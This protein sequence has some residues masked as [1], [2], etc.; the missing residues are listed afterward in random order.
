[1]RFSQTS[2]LLKARMIVLLAFNS[3]TLGFF[4]LKGYL[5]FLLFFASTCRSKNEFASC[6]EYQA[7]ITNDSLTFVTIDYEVPLA[8]GDSL[9]YQNFDILLDGVNTFLFLIND[10][11]HY[12]EIYN[13]TDRIKIYSKPISD[14]ILIGEPNLI[15]NS[16]HFLGF[17]SIYLASEQ[18][19]F[20]IDT[21][22]VKQK[23]IINQ[24]ISK[25]LNPLKLYN[26]NHCPL[27]YDRHLKGLLLQSY[28]PFDHTATRKYYSYPI[29][30]LYNPKTTKIIPLPMRY[31]DM[32]RNAYFGFANHV[33]RTSSGPL[34]IYSFPVD[35]NFYVYNKVKHTIDTIPG[36][37]S[38]HSS[39]PTLDRRHKNKSEIKMQHLIK[40]DHYLSVL[41]D[42]KQHYYYRFLAKGLPIRNSDGTF[43]VWGDKELILRVYS[44]Q[45]QLLKEVHLGNHDYS[46]H[47]SFVGEEGLYLSKAHY[48]NTEYNH[49]TLKF[50]ILNFK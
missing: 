11:Q 28:S 40:I 26:L 34:N 31:P 16:I 2:H 7:G 37:Q 25:N 43:N 48:K 6:L 46:F 29:E 13:L 35:N 18:S 39:F 42:Q 33:F 45:G 23:F 32:Y 19:I 8:I 5:F 10:A 22:G 3:T 44:E 38:V 4:R 15:I 12:F 30:V 49:T 36:V 14:F 47:K 50:T 1:M 41:H 9:I 20:L 21:S 27:R 17:D 24:N